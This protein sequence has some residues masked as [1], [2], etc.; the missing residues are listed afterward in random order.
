[1]LI[2]VLVSIGFFASVLPALADTA[3]PVFGSSTQAPV[4]IVVNP[5]TG[6]P[7]ATA[8]L[9]KPVIASAQ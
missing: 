5:E 6:L 4:I 9:P 3:A 2:R 1:M 8:E 7:M